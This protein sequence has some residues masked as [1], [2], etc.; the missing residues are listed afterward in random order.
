MKQSTLCVGW[1]RAGKLVLM[2]MVLLVFGCR[3]LILDPRGHLVPREKRITIPD[4]GEQKG[5]FKN[6][7]LTL[8]YQ[9]LR[10]AGRLQISGSLQFAD[11]IAKNF[12]L[13]K[14]F[15][16][17]VLLLDE[18]GKIL[19]VVNLTSVSYYRTQWAVLPDYPLSFSTLILVRDDTRSI[20]FNYTGNAV[21]PTTDGG[22]M[23]FWE[24]PVY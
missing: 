22:M 2:G 8:A 20:A 16:L 4:S 19:D 18:Q 17:G 10:T 6:E 15:H 21:D 13:I 9:M 11:R 1:A 14:Y 12:P 5:V 24:Y 7:D 23:D 3:S